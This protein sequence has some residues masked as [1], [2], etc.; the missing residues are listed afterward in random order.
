MKVT[1]VMVS[2]HI[3]TNPKT[4]ALHHIFERESLTDLINLA[5]LAG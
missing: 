3:N 2:F 4:I 1:M 5:G